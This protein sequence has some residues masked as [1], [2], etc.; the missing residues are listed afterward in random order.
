ML[1]IDANL[2]ST[3]ARTDALTVHWGIHERLVLLVV[4]V[5]ARV[6]HTATRADFGLYRLPRYDPHIVCIL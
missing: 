6:F 1:S 5:D 2:L 3:L 4:F